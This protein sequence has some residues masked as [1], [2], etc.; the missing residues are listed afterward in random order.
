MELTRFSYGIIF[1]CKDEK[2]RGGFPAAELSGGTFRQTRSG[3]P[4]IAVNEYKSGGT[5]CMT[6]AVEAGVF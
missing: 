5:V 6:L 2:R 1:R 3:M 4:V